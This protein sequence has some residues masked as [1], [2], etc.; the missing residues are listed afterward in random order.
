MKKYYWTLHALAVLL[1]LLLSH[2]SFPQKAIEKKHYN[3]AM[4]MASKYIEKGKDLESNTAYLRTAADA[5]ANEALV[6]YY[7]QSSDNVMDWKQ[8]QA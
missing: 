3:K 6:S 1:L 5:I 8:S 7:D 2:C 4:S